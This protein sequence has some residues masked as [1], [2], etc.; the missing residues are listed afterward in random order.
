MQKED[1]LRALRE[2]FRS[3]GAQLRRVQP[4]TDTG[5][6]S[7]GGGQRGVSRGVG[8]RER[9]SELTRLRAQLDAVN[10]L[11]DEEAL[12]RSYDQAA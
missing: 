2:E 4:A 6:I 10:R 3:L 9:E 1:Q 12:E 11:V 5:L 8:S 7:E